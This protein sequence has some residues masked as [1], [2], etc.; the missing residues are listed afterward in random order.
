[1]LLFPLAICL[2]FELIASTPH[3]QPPAAL[4][5]FWSLLICLG[6]GIL[7]LLK[8]E[9]FREMTWRQGLILATSIWLLASAAGALPFLFSGTLQNPLHA[10]FESVSAFTTTGATVM[11][12]KLYDSSGR[13]IPIQ[14]TTGGVSYSYY[15]N[16]EPIRDPETGAIQSQGIE[17]V[18]RGILFWRS[19]MQ[20]IGGI[21]IVLLFLALLPW[22]GF[23]GKVLLQAEMTGPIK[24]AWTPR[25]IE[26]ILALSKIYVGLTCAQVLLLLFANPALSWVEALEI[27]FSTL[28][29]GG[30]STHTESIAAYHNSNTEWVVILFMTLGSLNFGLFYQVLQG[31]VYRLYNT[32]LIT[33]LVS[34]GVG[35]FLVWIYLIALYPTFAESART[36]IFQFVSAITSTGF[37]TAPY[38][39]WPYSAQ[40][41]LVI[42]MFLG[43]MS[44]ST[45]GGMKTIR[46]CVGFFTI[47]NRMESMFHP[48][49]IRILKMDHATIDTDTALNTLSYL[50]ILTFMTVLGW[51]LLVMSGMD[52]WTSLSSVATTL[53]NAGLGFGAAGPA[54]SFASFS[55]IQLFLC[56]LFMLLGRLEFFAFLVLLAPAFW[57]E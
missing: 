34:L 51:L 56:S 18:S 41:I 24:S 43:G 52:F 36:A 35:S 17:A 5:F 28:S 22:L 29:T 2:Y 6:L 42:A 3:P 31:R 16:I 54:A 15:G 21:G 9:R 26:T 39:I 27:T 40:L 14:S 53:N 20:W 55:N 8:R 33:F 1:M 50:V 19:F 48:G 46:Q 23:G 12:A 13:E 4:A 10:L 38:D 57:D 37:V 32:E 47:K 45:A 44:G 30:F 25:I 7:F 49:A 11:Q